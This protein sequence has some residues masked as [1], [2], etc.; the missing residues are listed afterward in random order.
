MDTTT[1]C[2]MLAF[3]S[4]HD[5]SI[6]TVKKWVTLGLPSYKIGGIRRVSV[7]AATAWLESGAAN[8]PKFKPRAKRG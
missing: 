6:R 7:E 5:V 3:S 8:A 4:A 2:T 1:Y